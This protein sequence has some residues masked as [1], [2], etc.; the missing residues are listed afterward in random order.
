MNR[1]NLA[2]KTLMWISHAKRV[3]SVIELQHVLAV[4]PEDSELDWENF[5]EP[6]LIVDSCFGLVEIDEKSSTIR[7]VH[8]SL[9]E[10]LKSHEHGLFEN[11]DLEITKVCF[12]YLSLDSTKT[13]HLGNLSS[14]L[15]DLEKLSFLDYA[16]TQWG[17]HA[18]NV[19]PDDVKDSALNF[20][21]S[22]SHLL[23]AARV[24]DHRSPY[25][26][27]WRERM[28]AWA[29][30]DGAGISLCASFGLTDFLRLLIGQSKQ[31]MLQA[32]NMYGSTAL[33]EAAMKGYESTAELLLAH[34][35][36]V[37]CLNT[38]RSTALYLAVANSQIAM[39]RLLLQRE[40]RAQ[41]DVTGNGWWT[42]LH[43]AADIGN[44]EM[45]V[46]LLQKGAL[47]NVEEEKGMTPLHL[48]SQKGHLEVVRLLLLSDAKVHSK[49]GDRLTPLDLAVTGGHLEVSRMLLDNG[50]HVEH[51]GLDKWTA[52]HRAARRGH[53]HIVAL[54][55]QRGANVLTE[56]HKG[57]I[58]LHAAARSGNARAVEFLLNEKPDVKKD[59]LFKIERNRSTPRDVAF[60]MAHFDV[61]KLLRTAE[62]GIEEHPLGTIDKI[63]SA[64]ES[65][66]KDKVRRLLAEKSID[67]DALID[68]RQPALHFAMQEEQ[69]DI[70][71]VL[72]HF[73]AN[74][75]TIGYHGW[76]SLH[77]AAA[78]GNLVLTE[79]CL[80]QGANVH[81]RTDTAQTALHKACSS[82]NVQVVQALLDAGADK[83]ATNERDMTALHI[84]AHQNNMD[85]VRLLVEDHSVRI[86]AKDKFGVTA[87]GWA[88]RS[89]H[90]AILYYLRSEQ[91]KLRKMEG[92][93]SL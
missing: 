38:S 41:L 86:T 75:N 63:T 12:R 73:G 24:R 40:A 39:A 76:T 36:D 74:I 20:L 91:K 29:L 14:F 65:G 62:M 77:I 50:A 35:A 48:A 33:H 57:E 11:G 34:G 61:H 71:K 26:R 67:I 10:Y 21:R 25:F 4:R 89:G 5:V 44:E 30:S 9:Q 45:V 52:L 79:L 27:K 8:Y 55:L 28:Y 37:L 60:F 66:K 32:K 78:V 2:I 47:V 13:L 17:H 51:R 54:L 19:S 93:T 84:A 90:L 22:N 81:A 7:F 85:M 72:L 69:I 16:A 64:I 1:R 92:A 56:D 80:S 59:Q 15:K 88:E 46:L 83:E 49:N 6:Q 58:P 43:K 53:E 31:P 82:K 70:V 87:A 42:V 68:G 3:L 23:A 18:I